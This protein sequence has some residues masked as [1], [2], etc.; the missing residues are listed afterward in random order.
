MNL[1]QQTDRTP[2]SDEIR[3]DIQVRTASP[4]LRK[5]HQVLLGCDDRDLLD[6]VIAVAIE[7]ARDAVCSRRRLAAAVD[8][9]IAQDR[10]IDELRRHRERPA[11]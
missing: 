11:A 10:A 8:R 7:A 1:T 6:A 9:L 4:H 3:W 2:S 5:L